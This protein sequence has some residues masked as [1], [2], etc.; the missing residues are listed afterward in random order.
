MDDN[1]AVHGPYRATKCEWKDPPWG[2]RA[3][4]ECGRPVIPGKTYCT[5]CH[6]KAYQPAKRR[7]KRKAKA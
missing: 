3:V 7:R 6:S 5:D 1:T 4:S 2:G